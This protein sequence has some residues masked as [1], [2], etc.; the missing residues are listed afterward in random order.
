MQ[1]LAALNLTPRIDAA[2]VDQN[3][4]TRPEATLYKET[5]TL[6]PLDIEELDI[7]KAQFGALL[8]SPSSDERK[9]MLDRLAVYVIALRA[10]KHELKNIKFRG[11][12]PEDTE[13]GFGF[14]R[15]MFTINGPVVA[16]VRTYRTNWFQNFVAAATWYDWFY[17]GVAGTMTP[18]AL[19]DSFGLAITHLKSLETPIPFISECR[20][21]IGRTGILIPSDVRA[22]QVGDTENMTSIFPIPSMIIKP[23]ST[24]LGRA[25]ADTLGIDNV[26]LGGLVIGLGRVLRHETGLAAA[27]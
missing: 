18:F 7:F 11:L 20:F 15:P 4:C 2:G 21:E 5:M 27:W 10:I 3:P 6:G 1:R 22:L 9:I 26:A 25:M 16:G 24:L 19:P 12:N 17:E 13:L 8:A 23:E 14:I